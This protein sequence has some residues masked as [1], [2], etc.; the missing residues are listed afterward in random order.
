MVN[1]FLTQNATY[2]IVALASLMDKNL[3]NTEKYLEEQ[4]PVNVA[5]RV[6]ASLIDAAGTTCSDYFVAAGLDLATATTT[7]GDQDFTDVNTVK[8][9]INAT[10]YGD[11]NEYEKNFKIQT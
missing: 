11:G 7:C 10:W 2:D 4:L 1:H 8:G 5:A 6:T 3:N 9:V